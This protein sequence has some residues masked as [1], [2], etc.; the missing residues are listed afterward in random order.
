[1]PEWLFA[2]ILL[3]MICALGVYIT[4]GIEGFRVTVLPMNRTPSS[5][6]T[7]MNET[8]SSGR[9]TLNDL[10]T[11]FLQYAYSSL[12]KPPKSIRTNRNSP[13]LHAPTSQQLA[14]AQDGNG[15]SY[16][17]ASANQ[18]MYESKTSYKGP[19][20]TVTAAQGGTPMSVNP[21]DFDT[22]AENIASSAPIRPAL[23]DLIRSDMDEAVNGLVE[24]EVLQLQ[25]KYALA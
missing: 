10:N 11:D 22:E 25:N 8:P 2:L 12:T 23:R 19:W 15:L 14:A 4:K 9:T 21:S 13:Y 1:M 18:A 16:D 24:K 6:R 5:G 3:G 17:H 20:S 7:P